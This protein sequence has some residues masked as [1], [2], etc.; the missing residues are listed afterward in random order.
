MSTT[1]DNRV[2]EMQF[3]NRHFERNVS[4]TMSTLD[5]LKQSLNLTGATKGLE[6]IDT[7]AKRV[8]MAGLG[9]AVENVGLKF[10]AM[11]T[12]ADQTLR[13][14]TNRVEQVASRMVKALTIQPVTTG[15]QEYETQIGAVQTILANTQSKGTTLQDVNAALDELNTY[16]DKTIYNFTQMTK[17]I[18]TFTAAGVDLD[19]S[20]SSIKGIANLAA[21]SGSTSQQA[22]TAMYQLSQALAAGKVSLMDWNS[23]VNAGMGGQVFQ[24]ALKRTAKNMGT[25]VD[26][27]IKKYGSFRES[28]TQG[29][30]LTT[31]VLTETLT[32]LSGAY[33]EADL[34]AK[35]Y[36][37]SQAKEI[38]DLADTA[39]QAATKV[40]T[41]SQLWDTLQE[42][43]QSGWT[44]TWEII[45]GDFEE[46]KGFLT[47]ISD[48][49]GGMINEMNESRNKLL[50]GGLSTGWKQL[51]GTGIADE[52]GFQDMIKNVFSG[53]KNLVALDKSIENAGGFESWLK[54]GIQNGSISADMLS[55]SVSKLSEKMHGMSAE[56]RKAA[57]YTAEHL[58]SIKALD[59]GIKD[60][61]I[62]MDEF[63]KR[64]ARSSGRENLI[65]ALTN[66]FNGLMGVINP[67][68]E[69]FR[70]VFP[71]TTSEQ[72]YNLTVRIKEFTERFK[73]TEET[74]GKIKSTFKGVFAVFDI[75]LEIVKSVGKG[76]MDLIKNF[77]GIEGTILDAT[78]SIGDWVYN[79][80]DSIKEGNLFGRIVDTIVSVLSRIITKFKDFGRSVRDAF[81]MKEPEGF[82]GFLAGIWHVIRDIG[83]AAGKVFSALGKGLADAFKGV[84]LDTILEAV[85]G[86]LIAGILLTIKNFTKGLF[87]TFIG[88]GSV[89]D[90]IKG[91]LDDVRGCF[92][93]Y[94][95]QLK[96]GA[97]MKI[98]QAIGILVL[99]IL[100]LS[101]IDPESLGTALSGITTLFVELIAA[102]GVLGKLNIGS[103]MKA[104]LPMIAMSVAITILAAAMKI[105][106]TMDWNGIAKGLVGVGVLMAELAGFLAI[107]K[108]DKNF[109]KVAKG[110]IPLSLALLILA[111]ATKTFAN[112]SWEEV[113]KGL[114]GIGGLLL[115][116]ALFANLTGNAKHI[117]ST[118][119]AMV[120]LGASMKIFASVIKDFAKMKWEEI[121]KGLAAMAGALLAVGI[122]MRVMPS[123]M[124]TSGLGLTIVAAAMTILSDA[125][126][127]FGSMR[128][129]EIGKALAAMGG[130]L[131]EI[132][133][134]LMF[135][136]GT[137]GGSAA[138]IIAAGALAIIAPV[139]KSLGEM[140]WSEIAKGLITIAG[141]FA[142]V[143]IAGLLLGPLV[144]TILGLAGSFALF[145]LS[146]VGIGAGLTLIGIGLTAI[147]AGFTALAASS[148]A[149]ATAV[150]AALSIII[151]GVVNLIPEIVSEL[152]E[153]ILA[154]CKVI[155]DV[156]PQVAESILVLISEVLKSLAKHGPQITDSLLEFVIGVLKSIRDHL[157]ELIVVAMEVIGAFF[158]G[159]VDALG[160]I[161]TKTI[162]TGILAVGLISGLMW[163]LSSV[164]AL[165]P[166]A[167]LG[168]LGIGTVVAELALV[169]A[170]IGALA[171]I[172]GLQWLISEGGNFLQLIGT[173]IGQFFG[174]I[175]GGIAA[176]ATSV[177]PEIGTHLSQFM[178]NGSA[179]FEGVKALGPET[180]EGAKS[181]AEMILVLTGAG[182]LDALTSFITGG[183]V[184]NQFGSQ[185][186]A[187]GTSMKQF[188][189]N[190]G[191]FDETKVTSVTCAANAI[192]ALAK[193]SKS[194]DGQADWAKKLFGDNSIAA[195]A[196]KL[197]GVGTNLGL[198]VTNLGTFSEAQVTTVDNAVKAIKAL[199]EL[200]NSNI[201]YFNNNIT[202][203]ANKL[204]NLG[205]KLASFCTNINSIGSTNV[206]TAVTSLN[207]V[208]SA[209]KQITKDN[210]DTLNNFGTALKNLA[211]SGIK[212][213]VE[214]FTS[215]VSKNDIYSAANMLAC[216]AIEGI[217]SKLEDFK[218]ACNGLAMGGASKIASDN[219]YANFYDVGSYLVD[220]FAAGISDNTYKAAAKAAAM[221]AAA[222]RAAKEELDEHS[223]SRVGYEIGDFF[224]IA[225][226]NGIADNIKRAYRSSTELAKSAKSGISESISKVADLINSDVDTQPTIRPVLDL[227]DV[228]AG[229]GSLG[230]LFG[231]SSIGVLANVG[232]ASAAMSHYNQNGS[233]DDVVSAIKD[234]K[235][236]IGGSGDTYQINGITYD[237]GSNIT[238]A[239]R[240]L[241][242]AAKVERR[243]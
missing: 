135:M 44:Q 56:E 222:E 239:V 81:Q 34:I 20:V 212:S 195:F 13:N 153:A 89:L 227:S 224:G 26:K 114:A 231:D 133:I 233:N 113:G 102:L 140:S 42:A 18:G 37:Q 46:A 207:S 152:G 164:A 9:S 141:A 192:T 115:E 85:N 218:S 117:K 69:A 211:S 183:N 103:A 96:A 151:M 23:V 29:E 80:R 198:F 54:T 106:S 144:P 162:F 166:G 189:D 108:I 119:V 243:T 90:N 240:S 75:L 202:N 201:A 184:L 125:M 64:I 132:A 15:L 99:S 200:A 111:Q 208:M 225:F 149:G 126:S 100:V 203:F 197:P 131:A 50:Q 186:P 143:G 71:R 98:A 70:E 22:S 109:K 234:L 138:L 236:N 129:S 122:A 68:K 91:I 181:L 47:T 155:G 137:I 159:L 134:A 65:E 31:E 53:G 63:A 110:M 33:T 107:A 38:M 95:E 241:V 94:Q 142:V 228:R 116:V 145:A 25:D 154:F 127:D 216:K 177:L 185:L 101:T 121:G 169:L 61:T 27:I 146:F 83:A 30:W 57:G 238:E 32:Q 206:S 16:A 21:V 187:L 105:M 229:V 40:K 232:A 92:Q 73:I 223:P 66:A 123:N 205:E 86:G 147:A 4:T 139:L 161:D 215:E 60:G 72:L 171:Q 156:A 82:L 130:A 79:L 118:G 62:S 74:A 214:E 230:S 17:N 180:L 168:V 49:I 179:F 217:Q 55:E 221:A 173:A 136:N 8:N 196:D 191:N 219:N 84:N 165:V 158:Q 14:I 7:A 28:L 93:A 160:T 148:T 235:D 176:G 76:A 194:I 41:F 210:V 3:D 178:K 24:D 220:G 52:A 167:M 209:A 193:A 204:P 104:T 67:I 39:V 5:K 172:P 112:M 163:V 77:A 190:L 199:A 48:T 175:I 128:W 78:S 124:L 1:I 10:S 226:V 88:E 150:V 242:R 237:D 43:A 2:V 182:I 35:G 58:A 97:L 120:L 36:T 19:T 45:I 6:N 87:G 174:G 157:P 51:L 12:I 170:A 11:Y 213:F 188:A 59:D